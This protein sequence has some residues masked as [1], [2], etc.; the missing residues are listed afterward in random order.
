MLDRDAGEWR[1]LEVLD[2][3]LGLP[4][5]SGLSGDVLHMVYRPSSSEGSSTGRTVDLSS[6]D[7]ALNESTDLDV[8][9]AC[10]SGGP[11][12]TFDS[13]ED[14]VTAFVTEDGGVA[15]AAPGGCPAHPSSVRRGVLL[16]RW[17]PAV[18]ALIA[19]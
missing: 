11:P 12:I 13:A 3:D 15:C 14:P 8:G 19:G 6:A 5:I 4:Q 18:G 2:L 16:Q 9:A 10:I 1:D 17:R 7:L